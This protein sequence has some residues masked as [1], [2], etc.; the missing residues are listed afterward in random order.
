MSGLKRQDVE[1]ICDQLESLGWL[2]RVQGPRRD[3]A[4]W[5]VNPEV[6]GKF[7]ERAAREA[8]ERA[9]RRASIVEAAAEGRA[10]NI[11]DG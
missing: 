10:H 7:A 6:H 8:E 11:E 3:S 4:H 5:D 9:A 2:F 1:V